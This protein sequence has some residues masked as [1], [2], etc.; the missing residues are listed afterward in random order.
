M[1]SWQNHYFQRGVSHGVQDGLERSF[2]VCCGHFGWWIYFW[3][4][5]LSPL[6]HISYTCSCFSFCLWLSMGRSVLVSVLGIFSV[7]G[8]TTCTK[9][10]FVSTL[11]TFFANSCWAFS[12]SGEMCWHLLHVLPGPPL[13][14]WSVVT[15]FELECHCDLI[16]VV[17]VATPP[18]D[19]C[20]LN[21]LLLSSHAPWHV[22]EG[23]WMWHPLWNFLWPDLHIFDFINGL[24][25]WKSN[26]KV[27]LT[28]F[29]ALQM[30]VAGL[31]PASQTLVVWNMSLVL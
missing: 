28:I 3:I 12:Q 29:S 11:V 20:Q 24:F 27:Y 31:Q 15:F 30:H 25:A 5:P 6:M 7:P 1:S 10:I 2:I 16:N 13:A 22:G 19:L 21:G 26:S 4:Y 17:A 9:M 14:L 18:L 8:P 23:L